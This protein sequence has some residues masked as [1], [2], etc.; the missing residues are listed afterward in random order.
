MRQ[1]VERVGGAILLIS[2][3]EPHAGPGAEERRRHPAA[4]GKERL[5]PTYDGR[6]NWAHHRRPGAETEPV[7]PAAGRPKARRSVVA[8]TVRPR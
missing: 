4:G 5:R 1:S 6:L 7:E 3:V 8:L 2:G